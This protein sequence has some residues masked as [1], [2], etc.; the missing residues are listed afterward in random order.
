[1]IRATSDFSE[2]GMI[3]PHVRALI[4]YNTDSKIL[5]TVKTN[6]VLYTQANAAQWFGFGT[7]ICFLHWKDGI[8]KTQF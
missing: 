4:A 8:G 3:N 2:T 1:M 6:G 7:I 5:P